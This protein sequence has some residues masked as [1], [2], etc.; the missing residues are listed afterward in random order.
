MDS[1]PRAYWLP[2]MYVSED[3]GD[4]WVPFSSELI[5]G[6][7]LVISP[8][9]PA[10]RIGVAADGPVITRDGGK[11]WQPV[12]E[13][14]ALMAPAYSVDEAEVNRAARELGVTPAQVRNRALAYAG[15][16]I[17]GFSFHSSTHPL[18]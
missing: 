11:T 6:S 9:N 3:A 1:S 10:I 18:F 2:G 8:S 15:N 14:S 4:S 13:Q 16:K 5:P 7:V 12:G 17:L